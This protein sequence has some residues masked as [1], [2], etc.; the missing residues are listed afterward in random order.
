MK[1]TVVDGTIPKERHGDPILAIQLKGI[2]CTHGLE[3]VGAHDAGGTHHAHFRGEEMHAAAPASRTT[4][5][6]SE[7]FR[8]DLRSRHTLGQGVAMSPVC[9]KDSILDLEMGADSHRDG[10]LT[11]I[12]VTGSHD[13][14]VPVRAG[15]LQFRFPNFEHLLVEMRLPQRLLRMGSGVDCLCS[16]HGSVPQN[17]PVPGVPP[18]FMARL[19][20]SMG[21]R[22]P[23]IHELAGDASNTAN[24]LMSRG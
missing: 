21:I 23:V 7:Q 22:V 14:A 19:P 24:P 12:G 16:G 8:R 18:A 9:R 10:F 1:G 13:V 4:G 11:D 5:G 3:D 6:P 2:A 15:K 20:P 17:T